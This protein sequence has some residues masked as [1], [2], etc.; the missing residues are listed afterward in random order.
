MKGAT[1]V[2]ILFGGESINVPGLK[3]EII[4]AVFAAHA[5]FLEQE[6][7]Q[8]SESKQDSNQLMN[9]PFGLPL[10]SQTL[11]MFTSGDSAFQFGIG[12][13]EG[14]GTAMQHNPAQ[15][16]APDLPSEILQKISA[17]VKIVAP[18]EVISGVAAVQDCN[19]PHCQITRAIQ[20]NEIESQPFDVKNLPSEIRETQHFQIQQIGE[21]LYTVMDNHDAS[22]TEY[23]VFLGRPVGCTCG[24]EGCVHLVAVLRS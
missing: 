1:L 7:S 11:P 19:C 16:D 8:Q 14:I 21:D 17:I 6:A 23:K 3:P 2:I 18:E 5:E 13:M 9:L 24:K 4:E 22:R 10:F 12:S 15:A 20:G